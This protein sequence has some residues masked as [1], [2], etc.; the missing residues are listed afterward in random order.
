[1]YILKNAFRSINRSKGRNILIGIIITVI[2]CSAT[3]GLSI[4][5]AASKVIESSKSKYDITATIGIDRDKMMKN[6]DSSSESKENMKERF[7]SMASISVSDIE[8][9]GDSKYVSSYYYTYSVGLNSD[10]IDAAE[11]QS[12]GPGGNPHGQSSTSFTLTGYSSYEAMEEFITGAYT[13][14]EGE[15]SSNFS[16]NSCIINSELATLNNLTVGDTIV[17]TNPNDTSKTYELIISGIYSDND[18]DTMNMFT[19]SVNTIITNSNFVEQIVSDD[20]TLNAKIT[21][22]FILTSEDVVDSF[23]QELYD[24]GLDETYSVNTNLDQL[25]SETES[26]QNLATFAFTTLIIILVIGGIILFIINLINVRERKYEIGVLRTIGMKKTS[27][28]SQFVSELLIVSV[29]S[30]ILGG[31]IGSMLSVP[32]ANKLL[33]QEIQSSEQA[34]ANINE[35]FG[36]SM[37]GADENSK[38]EKPSNMPTK[39]VS[40]IEK[41]TSIDAAIDIKVLS[42]LI[43]IGILLTLVSSLAACISISRFSPLT[44]LKERS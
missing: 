10:T 26:I 44:I 16:D 12:K 25:S 40:K 20:A 28:I 39:G 9:Y 2:A 30:L 33:E 43:G 41:V 34:Q 37:N 22:T 19:N 38:Q 7:N 23:E 8:S 13:I 3:I 27:V 4:M 21:P 18:T 35:H 6:V 29:I 15:I 11:T 24:K 14:T 1:M 31:F 32:T 17:L 5:N 42:E 36:R